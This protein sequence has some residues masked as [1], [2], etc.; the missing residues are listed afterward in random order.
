MKLVKNNPN[1]ERWVA[2]VCVH[3]ELFARHEDDAMAQA[4]AWAK[5]QGWKWD[6]EV[7]HDSVYADP[8]D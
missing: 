3:L 7:E 5:S 6:W 4:M 1:G 8:L 2:T